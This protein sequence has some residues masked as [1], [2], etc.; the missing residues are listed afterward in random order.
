MG[1]ERLQ[2]GERKGPQAALLWGVVHTFPMTI[3]KKFPQKTLRA[4][5]FVLCTR[6]SKK[7]LSA[8]FSSF[9]IFYRPGSQRQTGMSP[10]LG[11][12]IKG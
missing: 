2:A 3:I 6:V 11:S 7:W 10:V 8:T 5:H 9:L 4:Q 1:L 12:A